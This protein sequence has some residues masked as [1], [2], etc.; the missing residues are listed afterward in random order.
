MEY[1]NLQKYFDMYDKMKHPLQKPAIKKE[2][3][4]AMRSAESPVYI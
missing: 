4:L 3:I 2:V 1:K